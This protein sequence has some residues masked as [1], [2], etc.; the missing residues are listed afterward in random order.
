MFKISPHFKRY[1]IYNSLSNFICGVETTMSTHSMFTATGLNAD[2]YSILFNMTMKDIVGQFASIPAIPLIT[3]MSRYGDIKPLKYL[4]INIAIFEIATIIEYTTP[5]LPK[6]FFIPIAGIANIGKTV[7]LTGMSSF[8]VSMINRLSSD[9][10]NIMEINSKV[11]SISMVSFAFGSMIGL[12]VVK[13]IPNYEA[14]LAMLLPMGLL[15]YWLT[16]KAV[17]KLI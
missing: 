6:E 13:I 7:G 12:G 9:G 5:L 14:R 16:K 1:I 17:E 11:S 10:K 2:T 4:G 3:S 15:R 8:N